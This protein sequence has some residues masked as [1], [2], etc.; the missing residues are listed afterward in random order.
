ML[1]ENQYDDEKSPL[2]D[3][4]ENHIRKLV[5][6]LKFEDELKTALKVKLTKKEFKVLSA[7]ANNEDLDTLKE[8]LGLDEDRYEELST[9]LVKKL[10]QERI[11]QSI[12]F[13]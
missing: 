5:N 8:K 13:T 7:W 12:C 10:N 11:K 9:K 6:P 1:D 3:E 4:V 2:R